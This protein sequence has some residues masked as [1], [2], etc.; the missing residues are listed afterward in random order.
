M[1]LTGALR[2]V[3]T[4]MLE[5][6]VVW[7]LMVSFVFHPGVHPDRH[8]WRWQKDWKEQHEITKYDG[9]SGGAGELF[10]MSRTD[11]KKRQDL[12]GF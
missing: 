9:I 12:A 6:L 8:S 1:D 10:M 11:S 3:G 2:E 4:E 7:F 5:L